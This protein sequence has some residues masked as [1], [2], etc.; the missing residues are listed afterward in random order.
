MET[1][2]TNDNEVT[3]VD[4]ATS[5]STNDNSIPSLKVDTE[6][7]KSTSNDKINPTTLELA[8]IATDT[9]N[10][11]NTNPKK[12]LAELLDFTPDQKRLA[13]NAIPLG[14]KKRRSSMH[15]TRLFQCQD[16][17]KSFTQ[18]A[19]LSIHQV[20]YFNKRKHTGERPYV[21]GFQA[22]SKSFTQLG[23]LKTHERKHT[24]ERP[25]TVI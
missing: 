5:D 20:F 23:N 13:Q 3:V 21:C 4:T 1:D 6:Q 10:S 9:A 16:C 22:C 18:Q 8:K 12:R 24:G 14:V 25:F 17:E 7:K 11:S 15:D 19:H 2:K